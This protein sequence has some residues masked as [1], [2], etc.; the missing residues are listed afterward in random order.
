MNT[1]P[2]TKTEI[3]KALKMLK[4]RKAAGPDGIPPE[5]LKT[6]PTIT[7]D[8]LLPL[9][10]KIWTAKQTPPDWKKG[11]LVKIPQKGDLGLCKKWRGIM[12]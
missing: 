9:F 2:P 5:A 4:D 7:A 1:N 11:H 3:L 12:L 10:Q 6:D 8:L